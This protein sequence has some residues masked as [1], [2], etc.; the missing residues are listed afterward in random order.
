MFLF[1]IHSFTWD[2]RRRRKKKIQDN[3]TSYYYYYSS[4]NIFTLCRN[5][6]II[7]FKDVVHL[8][9]MHLVQLISKMFVL[10]WQQ[11]MKVKFSNLKHKKQKIFFL[12]FLIQHQELLQLIPIQ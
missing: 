10:V 1:P 5:Q 4:N 11:H 8:F 7:N 9:S 12:F 2:L 3:I 6:F